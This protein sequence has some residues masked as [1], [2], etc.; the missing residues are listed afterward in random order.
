MIATI[1]LHPVAHDLVRGEGMS[2]TSGKGGRI[3]EI[4][5]DELD[6]EA[7][8]SASQFDFDAQ[9]RRRYQRATLEV[10]IALKLLGANNREL[11]KGKA[12]L[13]DLSLDGAF[14]TGIEI[15][16]TADGVKPEEIGEFKRIQFTI[17]DG[18]FKGVEAA[19]VPVRVGG[20]LGGVGVKLE[21]GFNFAV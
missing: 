2:G 1:E 7:G 5:P 15:Q 12:L 8:D 19:A 10:P 20:G 3:R 14:L 9:D 16:E 11:C 4:A 17:M 13:R 6:F 18:P 21:T